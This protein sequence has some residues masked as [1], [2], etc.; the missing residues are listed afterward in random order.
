M[1]AVLSRQGIYPCVCAY[2]YVRVEAHSYLCYRSPYSVV[3]LNISIAMLLLFYACMLCL[4]TYVCE[5]TSYH[6]RTYIDNACTYSHTHLHMCVCRSVRTYLFCCF[7]FDE[8]ERVVLEL[9]DSV[10]SGHLEHTSES[11]TGDC[12]PWNGH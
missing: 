4:C 9:H 6:V 8:C 7:H 1:L 10:C 3:K 2:T 11:F 5:C 12:P